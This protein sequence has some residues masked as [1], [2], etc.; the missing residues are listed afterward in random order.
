MESQKKICELFEFLAQITWDKIAANNSRGNLLDERGIS[1]DTIIGSIQD[2]IQKNNSTNIFAQTA[3]NE[4]DRGGDLEIYLAHEQDKYVRFFLQAKILKPDG[5]YHDVNH[6]VK[7]SGEYQW[8][9][10]KSFA[11]T[12]E[13]KALYLFYNGISD[14]KATGKDCCGD[15]SEKQ[16]GCAIC[17]VDFVQKYCLTNKTGIVPFEINR[18]PPPIGQPWRYLPCCFSVSQTQI[19]GGKLRYYSADEIDMDPSFRAIF[20]TP[21]LGFL[22]PDSVEEKEI[23]VVNRKIMKKGWSP[24]GRIIIDTT[25]QSKQA[26]P[27]YLLS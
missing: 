27:I 22:T 17:E 8:D 1:K 15:H 2:Y 23:E 10:L 13:C 12:A 21:T 5:T 3:I 25:G 7:S 19:E 26:T 24:I 14:Y 18:T 11:L 9:L 20:S 6:S 16:Y 4:S